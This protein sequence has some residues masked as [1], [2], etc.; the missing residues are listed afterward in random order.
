MSLPIDFEE[1]VKAPP[2]VGGVGGY[3]YSISAK[4][5]MRNFVYA[6]VVV[7]SGANGITETTSTGIGGHQGRKIST[8][9]LDIGTAVGQIAVWDGSTWGPLANPSAGAIIYFDGKRQA[10]AMVF[11]S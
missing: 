7:D 1:K 9:P 4:D 11:P 10:Q 8:T 2:A 5:L 6:A 3:P